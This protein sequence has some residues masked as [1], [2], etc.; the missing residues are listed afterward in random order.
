MT[1]YDRRRLPTPYAGWAGWSEALQI[2]PQT[3]GP[4]RVGDAER[5]QA[6]SALGDHFAAG[7]I[8]RE[9]FDE[10]SEQAIGAR[11]GSD[12]APLFADLPAE[13]PFGAGS[14]AG[15]AAGYRPVVSGPMGMGPMGMRPRTTVP[16]P[17]QMLALLPALLVPMLLVGMVVGAVALNAPWLLWMLFWM[18]MFGGFFR[19]RR[20]VRSGPGPRR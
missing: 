20:H 18:A 2:Q 10:R 7:R 9:E 15:T 6:V 8:T 3:S 11:F 13:Q 4:V 19:R 14:T 17:L 1:S 5:D 12:L 16:G